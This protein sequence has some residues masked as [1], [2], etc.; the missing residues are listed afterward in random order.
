MS[1]GACLFATNLLRTSLFSFFWGGGWLHK[2]GPEKPAIRCYKYRARNSTHR[3]E[4][5]HHLPFYSSAISRGDYHITA[6]KNQSATSGLHLV[7]FGLHRR[8]GRMGVLKRSVSQRG[9]QFQ[10]PGRLVSFTECTLLGTNI[11]PEKSTLKMILLF[12]RWDMLT[13]W[14]VTL[15]LQ[16]VFQSG[17]GVGSGYIAKH[18]LTGYLEH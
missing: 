14:R 2:V 7:A 18:L 3:V 12:P 1:F 9:P 10:Q 15:M 13:S 11:S 5:K 16:S 8:F 4:K 6:L 17:F